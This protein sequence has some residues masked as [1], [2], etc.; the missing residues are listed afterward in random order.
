MAGLRNSP[1]T[2][3]KRRCGVT[4]LSVR[5]FPS[6]NLKKSPASLAGLFLLGSHHLFKRLRQKPDAVGRNNRGKRPAGL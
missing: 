6:K 5:E 2:L 4:P 1:T 3:L